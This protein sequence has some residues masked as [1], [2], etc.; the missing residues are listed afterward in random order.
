MVSQANSQPIMG[1][2]MAGWQNALRFIK[3]TQT[4]IDGIVKD[5]RS[6]VNFQGVVQPLEP[7]K[8]YLK[9]E[10]QRSW[11]WLQ[12]HAAVGPGLKIELSP[13][14]RVDWSGDVFKVMN[15]YNYSQNGYIEYHL[16]KDF[17]SEKR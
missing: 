11:T 3:I 2:A 1:A 6:T 4:I 15:E 16:V 17:Q 7:R 14:D 8:L 13:N 12:V 9:P 5:S 10:G